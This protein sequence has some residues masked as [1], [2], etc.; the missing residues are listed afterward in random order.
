MA[1]DVHPKLTPQQTDLNVSPQILYSAA[2]D[3]T[4]VGGGSLLVD[5]QTQLRN[6]GGQDVCVR[7]DGTRTY[8]PGD[9]GGVIRDAVTLAP[10]GN[11]G[12]AFGIACGWNDKIYAFY[13]AAGSDPNLQVYAADG[14]LLGETRTLPLNYGVAFERL[15]QLSGDLFRAVSVSYGADIRLGLTNTPVDP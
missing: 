12:G 5:G 13:P 8:G 4:A 9:A 1:V 2:V 7:N 10:L 11:H 6:I 3:Y 15:L 14:S